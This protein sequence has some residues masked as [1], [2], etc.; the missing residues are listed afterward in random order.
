MVL[1]W[2]SVKVREVLTIKR[3]LVDG[4]G[5]VAIFYQHYTFINYYSG[6][7]YTPPW[8]FFIIKHFPEKYGPGV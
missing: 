8:I 4:G 7:Q 3:G 5:D 6:D 2:Y 1:S